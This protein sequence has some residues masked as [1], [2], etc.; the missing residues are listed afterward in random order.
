MNTI[1]MMLNR[2]KN[3]ILK[4]CITVVLIVFS[5]QGLAT[6]IKNEI[7]IEAD[8]VTLSLNDL[9]FSTRTVKQI[10]TV[11]I[12]YDVNSSLDYSLVISTEGKGVTARFI[13]TLSN[14]YSG[15]LLPTSSQGEVNLNYEV[16]LSMDEYEHS[17]EN[18]TT[19]TFTFVKKNVDSF[20]DIL[21][22]END[23][24]SSSLDENTLSNNK[25]ED[26][27]TSSSEEIIDEKPDNSDVKDM[28]ESEDE[29]SDIDGEDN[30]DSHNISDEDNSGEN[31]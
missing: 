9:D 13:D 17:P 5:T 26:N 23:K 11:K 14:T 24:T 20:D 21:E 25:I 27:S 4:G 15:I 10:E 7:N 1:F 18:K 8:E 6:E 30:I 28:S 2:N 12:K 29:E 3:K 22:F 19:I 31:S 16:V